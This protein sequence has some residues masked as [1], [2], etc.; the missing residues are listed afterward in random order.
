L[1]ARKISK[2]DFFFLKTDLNMTSK[3]LNGAS[4]ALG[5]VS[6]LFF[7]V[8]AIGYSKNTDAIENVA[9]I[10]SAQ[11]GVDLYYGLSKAYATVEYNGQTTDLSIEYDS[12]WCGGDWCDKCLRDGRTALALNI[13]AIIFTVVVVGMSCALITSPK[14]GVQAS[15][16]ICSFLAALF[17]L[18]A[19][20]MF[21]GDCYTAIDNANSGS[22]D[23]D[24]GT[25]YGYTNDDGGIGGLELRWGPG[26]VLALVGMLLMWIVTIFQVAA[27][28]T[29]SPAAPMSTQAKC[30]G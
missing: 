18:I 24:D 8:G 28:F 30:A 20:A 22:D 6:A 15:S 29:S 17:S 27:I 26:A 2:T 12:I 25:T 11:G 7:V 10:M 21:M 23:G 13:L 1:K 19:V 5:V 3:G 16:A 9:W 4:I 14:R